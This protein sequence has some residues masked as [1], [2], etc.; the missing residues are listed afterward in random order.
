MLGSISN[1]SLLQP[2]SLTDALKMLRDEGPLVPMAGLHGPLRLAQLRD[3]EGHAVSEPVGARRAADDRRCA[4][5]VL[6]IG[7]L[8][9]HA[10]LIRSP[11]VRRRIPM[12]AAGGAR[13]RR[14]ADS[15]SRHARRQRG[16]RVA[17][18]RHAA[19]AGRRRRG[20]RAPERGRDAA[21]AVHRL[22]HRLPAVGEAPGRADHRLRD[23][24]DSRQAV[25]PQGRHARR[26]GDL[27]DRHGR[28]RAAR[29]APAGSAMRRASRSA[30]SPR[31]SSARREPKRRSPA[32]P[33][34][35]RR[36]AFWSRRSRRSTTS[37][38]QPSIAGASRR[39][40]WRGFG[41]TR[42]RR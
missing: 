29:S 5:I 33:R 28:S 36:S 3:V 35:T 10:D 32:A 4:A 39:T 9:T 12:L 31:R 6:T 27:E 41:A 21:G 13:S 34:S 22:L 38:Q 14:R 26:A 42:Q 30:A 11:L 24:R 17:G 1:R 25:V 20:R 37:A 15:E 16:E 23:P 19:G 40:C 8:A 2:R 18:G 7:A